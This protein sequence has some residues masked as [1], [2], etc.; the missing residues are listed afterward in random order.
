MNGC[1]ETYSTVDEVGLIQVGVDEI[2][3]EVLRSCYAP[4]FKSAGL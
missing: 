3:K 4:R 1:G 2:V